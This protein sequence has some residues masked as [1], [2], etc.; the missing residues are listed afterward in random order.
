MPTRFGG[1]VV[2][3]VLMMSFANAGEVKGSVRDISGFRIPNAEVRL[4]SAVARVVEFRTKTEQDGS[5]TVE[6]VQPG[7]YAIR[8]KGLV[9][10]RR[11]GLISRSK[12][13]R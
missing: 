11:W 3:A 1:L 9:F 2:A 5:F 12:A 8:A 7:V 6:D 4:I 13:M 10:V